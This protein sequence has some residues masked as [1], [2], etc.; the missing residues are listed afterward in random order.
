MS[1]G[2]MVSPVEPD[3]FTC[4]EI[5]LV[6]VR[7]QLVPVKVPEKGNIHSP[8]WPSHKLPWI[9]S[10]PLV[11]IARALMYRSICQQMLVILATQVT[12]IEPKL[13]PLL[14]VLFPQYTK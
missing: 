7:S 13:V 4:G 14:A 9:I 3:R 11:P 2:V 5:Q 12:P 6:V 1:H 8:V 10:W